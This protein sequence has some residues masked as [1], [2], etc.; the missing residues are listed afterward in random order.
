MMQNQ[1]KEIMYALQR[2]SPRVY[3]QVLREVEAGGFERAKRLLHGM[4]GLVGE[5]S[6]DLV[7]QHLT[8]QVSESHVSWWETLQ[9]NPDALRILIRSGNRSE[10]IELY[11]ER[12]GEDWQA[13]LDFIK[14]LE[15]Q[16]EAEAGSAAEAL[17][18]GADLAVLFFLLKAGHLDD[19]LRYYGERTGSPAETARAML[20]QMQQDLESGQQTLPELGKRAPDLDTLRFLLQAGHETTA[21]RYYRD[22][23]E[24]SLLEA[25]QAIA[26]LRNRE[27]SPPF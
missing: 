21:I 17:Q 6:V 9:E 13:S 18:G 25:R 14:G 15:K 4:S 1:V 24:V 8:A 22:C 16:P 26:H 2:S 7:L 10:A 20:M 11:H 19:A 12:T 5:G 23:T 27:V 3:E